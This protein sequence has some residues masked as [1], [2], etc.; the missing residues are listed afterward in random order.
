[1]LGQS[2]RTSRSSSL[3]LVTNSL[4]S[5][6]GR[7]FACGVGLVFVL[8]DKLRAGPFVEDPTTEED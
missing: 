1:M 3:R 4:I 6:G 5:E 7:G 2:G 8:T